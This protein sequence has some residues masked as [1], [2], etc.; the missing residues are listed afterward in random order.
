[1]LLEKDINDPTANSVTFNCFLGDQ[2]AD[3]STSLT[4]TNSGDQRTLE[5]IVISGLFYWKVIGGLS[6]GAPS[7][8]TPTE[9]EDGEQFG[10]NPDDV[11]PI[12][13][14]DGQE[15]SVAD[16]QGISE[17]TRFGEHLP[18]GTGYGGYGDGLYG[19]GY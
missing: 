19:Y 6:T 3:G 16:G 9:D 17:A 12:I 1:M 11:S 8:T 2:F 10:E 14:F 5:V 18:T 7:T 15:I 13:I 4:L